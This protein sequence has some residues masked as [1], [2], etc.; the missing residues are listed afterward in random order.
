MIIQ[1]YLAKDLVRTFLAV[2]VVLMLVATSHKLVRL[3]AKAASGEISGGLLLQLIGYQL[4]ELFAFLIPLALYLAI[5]LTFGRFS[6]ENELTAYFSTG[7]SWFKLVNLGLILSVI[8]MVITAGMTLWVVPH[9]EHQ[10]DNM[11]A[12]EEPTVL[13]GSLNQGRFYSFQ[14][15]KL[16]FYVE[17]L[18]EKKNELREVFIAEQPRE[19]PQA[20]DDWT[21]LTA[22]K[23]QI[24]THHDDGRAYVELGSGHR[25]E[26][27]PGELDYM[28]IEFDTYGRLLEKKPV[29]EG[30]YMYRSMPT[31]MLWGSP[32]TSFNGELQWRLSIPLSA[33]ILTLLAV[34]LSQVPPRKG[35]FHRLLPAIVIFI[36]YFNLLT[37]CKRWIGRGSLDPHIGVWWVHGIVLAMAIGLLLTKTG[38]FSKVLY[39]V[40]GHG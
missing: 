1:R 31:S 33:P 40:R 32:N 17:E 36:L 22:M 20:N 29:K 25:Y 8:L 21:V 35:R 9:L 27:V 37:M 2:F 15:D 6:V 11:I 12:Q 39:R 18:S 28:T 5:L 16:V 14:G 19:K 24:I 26:G 4:P 30:M 3:I 23:G 38:F 10:R 34:P 13:L 7:G